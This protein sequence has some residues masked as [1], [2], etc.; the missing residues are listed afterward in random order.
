MD[1]ESLKSWVGRSERV[2][3]VVTA[4][5]A[6]RLAATLDAEIDTISPGAK[7]PPLWHWLYALPAAPQSELGPDG[8]P[9]KGGFLPP[10]PL[11]RRM[12][13]GGRITLHRPILFGETIERTATVTSVTAKKGRSGPLVFVTVRYEIFSSGV[14]AV[15]EEQDLVYR[16]AVRTAPAS[17]GADSDFSADWS[18]EVAP[19]PAFLFRFS[20]L[21]FNAHRIHYDRDYAME[22][23]HH[24]D[25]VVQGPLLAILMLELVRRNLKVPVVHFS[26]RNSRAIHACHRFAVVGALGLA[27]KSVRLAVLDHAGMVAVRGDALLFSASSQTFDTNV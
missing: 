6:E 7:L 26:F 9:R 10:V 8:H 5:A 16:D 12:F 1:L 3:D 19:S 23:E 25:L 11:D 18:M 20:A 15:V 24:E 21:T 4:S 14:P 22:A 17:G 2:A 27:G 13:A